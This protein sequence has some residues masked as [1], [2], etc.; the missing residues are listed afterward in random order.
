MIVGAALAFLASAA[1]AQDSGR[2]SLTVKGEAR[3]TA[4]TVE[5][6]LSVTACADDAK[7]AEAKYRDRLSK[8]IT[9]LKEGKTEK[10]TRKSAAKDSDD[11]DDAPKKAPPAKGDG[12]DD[13]A[14]SQIP[15]EVSERGLGLGVKATSKDD[16]NPFKAL[17][18]MNGGPKANPDPPMQFQSHV[19]A[20]I[21]GVKDLDKKL[22][23]RRVAQ[24]IDIAIDAG[25]DSTESGGAP[26][27]AVHF[28]VKDMEAL[29]QAAYD[30]AM[31]K[32]K[33]RAT[34]LVTAG[35]RTLGSVSSVRENN[36]PEDMSARQVRNMFGGEA[37]DPLSG[38]DVK[39]EVELSV[40]FDVPGARE[41]GT[42]P[43]AAEQ[44]AK[45]VKAIDELKAA[46]LITAEQADAAK[47]K[48]VAGLQK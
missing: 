31:A 46:G 34:K 26:P 8:V 4:D 12:A 16:N 40:D 15:F 6:E 2:V 32:A 21:K 33:A 23:A 39:V 18:K 35:G 43:G 42:A 47:K 5:V 28:I 24:I 9:A 37:A 36:S 45:D 25:A 20:T 17:A 11:G 1:L 48:I 30:D 7:A 44:M 10:P 19:I 38:F 41:Q 14:A 27:P 3:A 13:G 29:H 22:V